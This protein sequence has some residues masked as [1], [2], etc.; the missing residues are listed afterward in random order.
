M[1]AAGA[2]KR[3]R[4]TRESARLIRLDTGFHERE[5]AG[6]IMMRAFLLIQIFDLRRIFACEG[7]ELFFAAG[8]WDAS[9]V[10]NEST[11]VAGFVFRNAVPVGKAANPYDQIFFLRCRGPRSLDS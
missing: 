3:D 7:F 10:K 2:A 6:E 8:V 11:A 1:L 5:H 4:Q 9:S